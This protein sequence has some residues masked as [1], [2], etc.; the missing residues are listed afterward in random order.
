MFRSILT[1]INLLSFQAS[2][3][4]DVMKRMSA[5][6]KDMKFPPFENALWE[7]IVDF[8][9]QKWRHGQLVK[10]YDYMPDTDEQLSLTA[11]TKR[12]KIR[13]KTAEENVSVQL[14]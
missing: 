6:L 10:N 1:L 9:I 13:D 3:I 5:S 2:I 4:V 12:R 8:L 7:D 11:K 14:K